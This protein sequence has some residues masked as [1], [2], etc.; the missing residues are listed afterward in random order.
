MHDA[1]ILDRLEG[2]CD[3]VPLLLAAGA[4]VNAADAVGNNAL[5]HLIIEH[6]ERFGT[7]SMNYQRARFLMR[8]DSP[9]SFSLCRFPFLSENRRTWKPTI[10]VARC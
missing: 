3:T 5:R 9:R 7:Y 10:I 2:V 4:N 1:V 6:N 8:S